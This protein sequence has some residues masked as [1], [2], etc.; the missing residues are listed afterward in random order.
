MALEYLSAMAEAA[1][2]PK[3][4]VV[5]TARAANMVEVV[6]LNRD[7]SQQNRNSAAHVLSACC[8]LP[9]SLRFSESHSLMISLSFISRMLTVTYTLK[10]SEAVARY[11]ELVDAMP[12][13]A[14]LP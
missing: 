2:L 14:Q 13:S 11:I 3:A 1:R 8:Q 5:L 6:G 4:G 10:Q 7:P 9:P 12:C